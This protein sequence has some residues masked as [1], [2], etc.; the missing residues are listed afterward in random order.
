MTYATLYK[1]KNGWRW[2]FIRGGRIVATSGE[3]YNEKRK[4][5]QSMKNLLISAA[6]GA[7]HVKGA[8]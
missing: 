2:R 6:K 4:A 8:K 7:V 5:M 3:A 1:S